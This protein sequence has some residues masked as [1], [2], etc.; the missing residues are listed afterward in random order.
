MLERYIERLDKDFDLEGAL[1][2]ETAGVFSLPLDQG[3]NLLLQETPEGFYFFCEVMPIS[4]ISEENKEKFLKDMLSLNLFGEEM[5][6]SVIGL[7]EEGDILTLSQ[8]VRSAV[9][10]VEFQEIAEDF[11]NSVDFL[12]EEARS[13]K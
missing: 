6:N 7:S 2:I 5:K 11:M 9:S 13:Y 4:S 3:L 8:E 12:L 10:Y 1:L